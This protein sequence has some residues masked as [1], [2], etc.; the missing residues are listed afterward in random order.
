MGKALKAAID[1]RDAFLKEHPELAEYQKEIQRRLLK[2]GNLENRL[3]IL[4]FMTEERILSLNEVVN[5]GR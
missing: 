1:E 4:R 5:N 3:A 2:A